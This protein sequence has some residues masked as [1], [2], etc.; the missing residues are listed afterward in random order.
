MWLRSR[1]VSS[2][3]AVL[4][5]KM[6]ASVRTRAS[7]M[8]RS[9]RITLSRSY[10]RWVYFSTRPAVSVSIRPT[11]LSTVSSRPVMSASIFSPSMPRIS[12]KFSTA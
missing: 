7:S 11:Q 8:E 1:T 10:S 3:T 12:T 5:P 6:A 9:S 2:S 4:S